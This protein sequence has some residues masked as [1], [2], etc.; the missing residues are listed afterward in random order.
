MK[1][2]LDM[3]TE[4][5]SEEF[6]DAMPASAQARLGTEDLFGERVTKFDVVRHEV[7]AARNAGRGNLYGPIAAWIFRNHP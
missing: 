3:T 2:I 7:V 4:E 5:L 1:A 6:F